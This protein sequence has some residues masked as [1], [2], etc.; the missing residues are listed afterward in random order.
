[1]TSAQ[2]SPKLSPTSGPVVESK[3][4]G[5][6]AVHLGPE[7][8]LDAA[9]ALVADS[10]GAKAASA[11]KFLAAA[12]SHGLDLA[13]TWGVM[14]QQGSVRHVA[15]ATPGSGR[16]HMMFTSPAKTDID[17]NE[18]SVAIDASCRA[19]RAH[20][21]AQAL[22][23]PSELTQA[24]AYLHAG[25]SKLAVL[26]YLRRKNP[27]AKSRDIA[28]PSL[29]RGVT[30]Q[31]W[32]PGADDDF[33]AALDRSYVNTLDCPELC[34]LRETRDVLESHKAA[35][36]F[37]P[38]LWWIV[39][40]EGEPNGAMLFSPGHGGAHIELV[41]LGLSPALRGKR[42][43]ATLLEYGLRVLAGRKE[44]SITCAVDQR[45]KPAR[46][47]YRKAGF[48]QFAERAAYIRPV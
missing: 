3:R 1:M 43:G 23:D 8:L 46:R 20:G 28:P 39:R 38:S 16:T 17:A 40:A 6:H 21:L 47:L 29:P 37:E 48:E 9:R 34:G 26:G 24:H 11:Q 31:N 18:L 42:L 19:V 14:D 36:V 2:P 27:R 30:I 12:A 10:S 22:L 33:I 44:P 41:Y 35:G 25:F 7:R 5:V 32:T 45:N 4:P 15:L 13:N